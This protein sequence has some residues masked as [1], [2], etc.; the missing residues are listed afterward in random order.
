MEGPGAG[1]RI[2]ACWMPR[3]R[4]VISRGATSAAR[5]WRS[6]TSGACSGAGI[7][8]SRTRASR[9]ATAGTSAR[10][11]RSRRTTAGAVTGAGISRVGTPGS[12]KDGSVTSGR[13][14]VDGGS[15]KARVGSGTSVT[16]NGCGASSGTG[17]SRG[18]MGGTSI[19]S[20]A[21][22]AASASGIAAGGKGGCGAGT[23]AADLVDDD[24]P[25]SGWP[26]CAWPPGSA[27][28]PSPIISSRTRLLSPGSAGGGGIC[29]S[30]THNRNR[31]NSRCSRLLLK[32]ASQRI[33]RSSRGGGPHPW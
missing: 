6:R 24:C 22:A 4:A 23:D 27:G 25:A 3:S 16:C 33:Q 13:R 15:T 30:A 7:S 19:A 10:A 29:T 20:A 5:R 8:R 17:T 18:G 1:S 32:P 28:L 26:A 11:G 14:A 31:K 12:R 2:C 21:G 9:V